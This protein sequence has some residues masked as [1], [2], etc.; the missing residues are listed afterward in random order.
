M[1]GIESSNAMTQKFMQKRFIIWHYWTKIFIL[2]DEPT[3]NEEKIHAIPRL[4]PVDSI[5][6]H[7]HIR[8]K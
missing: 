8:D 2:Q 4:G 6:L 7:M 1:Q 5:Y 3:K